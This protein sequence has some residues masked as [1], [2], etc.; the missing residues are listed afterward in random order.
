MRTDFLWGG[1][2]AAHQVEGAWREGGKG[3]SI[4]D[5]MTAGSKNQARKIT[6]SIL[7]NEYYPNH[8]GIDFYHYYKEDIAL[9]AEMGFKALRISIA[10]TRIFPNGDETKPNEEGLLF[11]DNLFDELHKHGIEPVVT[12]SHF[13]M[14]YHLVSQY[15]AWRNR[16]MIEFF[17]RFST[18]VMER[19]KEKVTYW[20]TFN[21]I[22]NQR[23]INNP[24]YSFTNSGVLFDEEED[25][26]EVMYQVAHYQFVASAETVIRGKEINP[27]FQIGCC[28]A[29]TPNYALTSDA[30]DQ[31]LAQKEDNNQLFFTDLQVKG[32]YPKRILKEWERKKYVLD[33]TEQDLETIQQGVV[34]YIGM[35][36]YLSNT[37]SYSKEANYL[38]DPLLGSETLVENPHA[39]MTEWGWTIDPIGFRYVLN[40]LEDRYEKPI[41]V[42]ENGFGFNDELTATG[43]H[44]IERVNYLSEHIKQMKLAIE[45]DGVDVIGYTVWGCIDPVSFTTGE[46]KK[47]YGFIYV[48]KDNHGNGTLKR[49]KKDSFNWY[50]EIIK[51]D[52]QIID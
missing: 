35:T 2:I 41:F 44:D 11:Y 23:I 12:L 9:F 34:D 36:Y 15:G 4:A 3:I 37:V 10:W 21:E 31:L 5:V 39:T 25:K 17:T 19:Y 30:S 33:I 43:I 14:P 20:L 49:I 13:E 18:T 32:H 22:N 46:M 45:E 24:I 47:R 7:P 52:G 26:L 27:D 50:K 1:A 29:A 40:L 38:E 28:L 6:N 16:K 42:V 51:T 48:D 8:E